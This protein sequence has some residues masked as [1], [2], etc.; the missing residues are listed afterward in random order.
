MQRS[1]Y[2][3]PHHGLEE[4][5]SLQEATLPFTVNREDM[6]GKYPYRY[7]ALM[8]V[9]SAIWLASVI[10]VIAWMNAV[11]GFSSSMLRDTISFGYVALSLLIYSGVM[12]FFSAKIKPAQRESRILHQEQLAKK[13]TIWF[14]EHGIN[15]EENAAL[16]LIRSGNLTVPN[17]NTW[18]AYMIEFTPY[19]YQLQHQKVL[20][21]KRADI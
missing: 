4:G 17:T 18:G 5:E 16:Q 10:G 2:I 14:N 3:N 21:W 15:G 9:T 1:L 13:F 6:H 7:P 19:G 11:W 8:I 12:S 20:I